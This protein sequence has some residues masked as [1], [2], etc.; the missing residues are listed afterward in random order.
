MVLDVAQREGNADDRLAADRLQRRWVDVILDSSS[1][2]MLSMPTMVWWFGMHGSLN[3]FPCRLVLRLP[4]HSSLQASSRR[5]ERVGT[6]AGALPHHAR[7][8]P[9]AATKE[10]CSRCDAGPSPRN[11]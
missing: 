4:P 3:F 6:A 5:H 11:N 10:P 8:K 2:F 9:Q 7:V 1:P